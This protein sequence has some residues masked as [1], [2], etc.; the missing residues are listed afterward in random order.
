MIDPVGFDIVGR[1][2][3]IA[4]FGDYPPVSQE[5]MNHIIRGLLAEIEAHLRAYGLTKIEIT[6]RQGKRP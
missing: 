3:A 5:Q 4:V 2:I 1:T 6:V